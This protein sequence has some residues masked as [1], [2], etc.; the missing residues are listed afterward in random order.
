MPAE[1]FL[2]W[3]GR[4]WQAFEVF[5]GNV[6]ARDVRLYAVMNARNLREKMHSFV[7]LALWHNF[8]PFRPA[9]ASLRRSN[10]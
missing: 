5:C 4:E 8:N 9:A 10:V 3:V 1:L 7:R 6:V 2:D